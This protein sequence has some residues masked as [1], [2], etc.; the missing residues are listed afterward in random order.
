MI[1]LDVRPPPEAV[2]SNM[3]T[4]I[5]SSNAEIAVEANEDFFRDEKRN[6]RVGYYPDDNFVY[7]SFTHLSGEE[8]PRDFSV[9]FRIEGLRFVRVKV[10]FHCDA[11]RWKVV[12]VASQ[13]FSEGTY[14]FDLA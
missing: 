9:L 14:E 6:F 10:T 1:T 13:E 7:N 12:G 2:D 5:L 3:S 8:E 4:I 11:G